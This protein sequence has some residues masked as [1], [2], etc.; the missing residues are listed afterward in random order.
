MKTIKFYKT[1]RKH[2]LLQVETE[3]CTINIRIYLHDF[4]YTEKTTI[5]IIPNDNWGIEAGSLFIR[6]RCEDDM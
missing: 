3:S 4:Q 5:Q 1:K 6:L 2:D